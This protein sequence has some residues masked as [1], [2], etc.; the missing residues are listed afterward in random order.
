MEASVNVL[1]FD[2]SRISHDGR[3]EGEAGV[4]AVGLQ[5]SGRVGVREGGREDVRTMKEMA[6]QQRDNMIL[7]LTSKI[8][9]S[10]LLVETILIPLALSLPPSLPIFLP[11]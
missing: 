10:F 1:E 11:S 9:Q 8:R 7:S 4:V 2:S 3:E 6:N 5:G